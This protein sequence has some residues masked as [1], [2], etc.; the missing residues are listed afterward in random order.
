[1]DSWTGRQMK[2]R[3]AV[4]SDLPMDALLAPS[5]CSPVNIPSQPRPQIIPQPVLNQSPP[6]DTQNRPQF[7]QQP[8]PQFPPQQPQF[9]PQQQPPPQ[10]FVPQQQPQFL[11][12]PQFVQQQPQFV[13]QQPFFGQQQ[14]QFAGQQPQFVPQ[15]FGQGGKR[16]SVTTICATAVDPTAAAATSR[17]SGLLSSLPATV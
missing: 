1:M 9:V 17:L 11:Q 8:R 2:P 4:Q 13:P 6:K 7:V 15:Q 3:E 10:Q 14:P 12:Q 5:L 16:I